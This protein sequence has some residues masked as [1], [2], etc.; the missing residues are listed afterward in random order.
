MTAALAAL[1]LSGLLVFATDA[2]IRGEIVRLGDIA[3]VAVLPESIRSRAAELQLARFKRYTP[4]A[5]VPVAFLAAQARSQMPAL[6]A[7]LAGN[8]GR[9]IIL[10][11]RRPAGELMALAPH[12]EGIVR[13]D[14][15]TLRI[16]AGPFRIEREAI[17]LSDAKPGERLFLRTADRQAISAQCQGGN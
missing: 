4:Q 12:A 3:N 1:A 7:W 2:E 5:S 15:V 10:R 16:D 14:Q 13:G 17:A 6:A 8:T 9:Q 11:H